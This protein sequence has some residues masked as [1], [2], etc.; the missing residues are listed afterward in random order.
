[1]DKLI[2]YVKDEGGSMSN[3]AQTINSMVKCVLLVYVDFWL[4]S[5]F[6]HVFS[7]T[8]QYVCNDMNVNLDFWEVN[9]KAM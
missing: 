9:L 6:H 2:A 8:C 5:C 4:G 7:K 1:M 3:F